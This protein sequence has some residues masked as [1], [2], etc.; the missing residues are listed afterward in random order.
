VC[1]YDLAAAAND[2]SPSTSLES[3]ES[4]VQR[5]SSSRFP[6]NPPDGAVLVN[7][8]RH[9]GWRNRRAWIF[10]ALSQ[11][12]HY[13]R[14]RS[15][16][17]SC[18]ASFWLLR[19]VHDT[20]LFKRVPD[21]C[22]DRWC[23][24]CARQRAATITANLM[25]R[26]DGR[27]IRFVTLTLKRDNRSLRDR[28]T[29]L[30]AS[31]AKLRKRPWW[32]DVVDGGIAFTEITRGTNGDHWHPHLHIIA[33]G[34]FMPQDVLAREWLAV[35]GDSHIVD[36]RAPRDNR[37][38]ANYLTAYCTKPADAQVLT[39]PHALLEAINALRGRKLLHA[40]GCCA[41]WKLLARPTEADWSYYGHLNEIIAL[42]AAGD[43]LAFDVLLVLEYL[44]PNETL[45]PFHVG[46]ERPP[47]SAASPT[48]SEAR[49]TKA[50]AYLPFSVA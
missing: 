34:R 13:A 35:T 26:I 7:L 48:P 9:S 17:A 33:L 20:T 47:P 2:A 31:F 10:K 50:A 40:F 41:D 37:Q 39:D 42:A 28:L 38:V 19:N 44:G 5:G 22:R 1:D 46:E 30:V 43:E 3:S 45:D 32:L 15:R 12:Y 25:P 29:R 6:Q 21:F 49:G 36:V 8:F 14:R 24:P 16:F 23:V 11:D 27:F 18:G 4:T